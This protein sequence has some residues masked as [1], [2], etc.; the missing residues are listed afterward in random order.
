LQ[1]M[2]I[3]AVGEIDTK[4][5]STKTMIGSTATL[6][7]TLEEGSRLSL[8]QSMGELRL[9]V[10]RPDDAEMVGNLVTKLEDLGRPLPPKEGTGKEPEDTKPAEAAPITVPEFKDK[11]VEKEEPVKPEVKPEP[12]VVRPQREEKP[13][14]AIREDRAERKKAETRTAKREKADEEADEEEGV[15]PIRIVMNPPRPA[16]T[17]T[18]HIR[19]G[20]KARKE[21]VA[22]KREDETTAQESDEEEQP[23][24][25]PKKDE[26]ANP[27]P[28]A[29]QPR[30]GPQP[31]AKTGSSMKTGRTRTGGN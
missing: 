22:T 25:T 28:R 12:E 13:K 31:P 23:R 3:L 20:S 14:G 30:N 9:V 26:K 11:Q 29:E 16:Q 18:M 15:R 5:P 8:G 17:H 24:A 2:L 27:Q 4:D 21:Q 6:A 10:R 19:E 7:A 1:N